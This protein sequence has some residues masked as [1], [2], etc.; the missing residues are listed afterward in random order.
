MKVT[1]VIPCYQ[2]E[3][4]LHD[5]VWSASAA[6]E[7]LVVDDA[8]P[9][10]CADLV[11]SWG[12]PHVRCISLAEN[13]GLGAA[14]NRGT[15]E[16]SG[17]WVAFLDAD[18]CFEPQWHDR[19]LAFLRQCGDTVWAYHPIREWDGRRSG[20]VRSGDHP[21][22]ISDWVLRRP[23]VAPS[24]CVIRADVA[25]AHPFDETRSL[26]G[27]EDLELWMRLWAKG[28]RPVR[29]TD[30]AFTR[31]RIGHGMSSELDSH[32]TKVR[33][34]WAQFVARGWIPQAVLHKAEAELQRQKARSHHKAGRFK[35]AQRAYLTAGPSA[36]NWLLAAAAA[37][38]IKI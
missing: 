10:G 18:D 4:T 7:I 32:A 28:H 34:R 6:H 27:T 33:L 11:A 17:D 20:S 13:S 31:Y 9:D 3:A 5:A 2:G 1:V 36:K 37:I 35:E 24:A 15:A 29:W 22:Q 19:L 23:A 26:Q 12:L 21:T 25:R 38:R 30:E 14:R 16:A 8:S